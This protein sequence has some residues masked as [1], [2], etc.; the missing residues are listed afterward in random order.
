[1]AHRSRKGGWGFGAEPCLGETP[2][3][4]ELGHLTR[5]RSPEHEEGL[6]SSRSPRQA[7]EDRDRELFVGVGAGGGSFELEQELEVTHPA[8]ELFLSLL[9]LLIFPNQR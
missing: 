2:G 5:V 8:H 1:R 9:Q 7:L 4:R 6:F 3:E